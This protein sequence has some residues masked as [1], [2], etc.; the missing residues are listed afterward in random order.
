MYEMIIGVTASIVGGLA[1][2]LIQKIIQTVRE[3]NNPYTG[4]WENHIFDEDGNIIKRD[5]LNVYQIGDELYGDIERVFPPNQIHRRW[6]MTGRLKGKDFFAIFWATDPTISSYG[7]WYVHQ[8][9]DFLF[10][11]YYLKFDEKKKYGIK[12]IR[13]NF[14]KCTHANRLAVGFSP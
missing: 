6:K 11:G 9:D 5:I 1:V 3:Q 4:K 10:E 8:K 14:V 2:I 7:S 13:L 12:P